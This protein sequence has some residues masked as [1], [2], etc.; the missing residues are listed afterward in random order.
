VI[1]GMATKFF[2][3]E[4]S[5]LEKCETTG[6]TPIF[7]GCAELRQDNSD[8]FPGGYVHALAMSR[9]PGCAMVDIEDLTEKEISIIREQLAKI[10]E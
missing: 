2:R 3:K 6:H 8:V 4:C 1:L 9:V 5:A 10:L 7:Y